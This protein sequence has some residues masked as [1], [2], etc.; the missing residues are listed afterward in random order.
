MKSHFF[1]RTLGILILP[2]FWFISQDLLSLMSPILFPSLSD[3]SRRLFTILQNGSLAS[4]FIYTVCR[5]LIG[6]SLGVIAGVVFGLFLGV[7]ETAKRISEFPVEFMR[8]MPVTAIF[9]LFLI[10]FGIGDESKIA[11][12][13]TPTFLLMT[14]NTMYGVAYAEPLRRKMAKVFGAS[15]WQ[16]FTKIVAK[17]ALPQIFVGLRLSLAQSLIVTVVSEMFI[18]TDFGLGQRVYDSYLTNSITTLYA[19]LIVLGTLGYLANRVMLFTEKRIL[20]WTGK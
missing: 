7:S 20:F 4:D 17:D 1:E 12:A 6:F 9:P 16:I 14:V 18:G 8:S 10:I 19:L 13:F 11:M 5:W 2:L 15:R 3:V